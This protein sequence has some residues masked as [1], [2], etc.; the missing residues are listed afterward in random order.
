[1]IF[2]FYKGKLVQ[3]WNR[4]YQRE[5]SIDAK[6]GMVNVGPCIKRVKAQ[7]YKIPVKTK[8]GKEAL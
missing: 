2:P 4:I 1:L 6:G 8:K 5:F 3:L 7:Y